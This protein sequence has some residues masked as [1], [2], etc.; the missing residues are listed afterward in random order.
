MGDYG[1]SGFF[2]TQRIFRTN[3]RLRVILGPMRASVKILLFG[4]TLIPACGGTV[5][6]SRRETS[7]GGATAG[8]GGDSFGGLTATTGG[9]SG[10]ASGGVTSTYIDPGCPEQPVPEVYKECEPLGNGEDCGSGEGCYPITSY[11]TRTCEPEIFQMLCLPAGRLEQWDTCST[12]TDCSPGYTCVVSGDGTMCLKMCDP[13]ATVSCPRG[14]FCDAVD[15]QGI[16]IC[17]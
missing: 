16:G 14:L 2:G 4:F 7:Q 5:G 13:L 1:A 6:E 12:I 10:G 15:L 3:P 11:P 9:T 17:F 8:Q